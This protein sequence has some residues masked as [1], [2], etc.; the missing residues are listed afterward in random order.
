[1]YIINDSKTR[2]SPTPTTP[3]QAN[4]RVIF[5]VTST[6]NICAKNNLEEKFQG[7]NYVGTLH[8]FQ[9]KSFKVNKLI[10]ILKELYKKSGL[11]NR[12]NWFKVRKI[13]VSK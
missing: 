4:T 12:N 6:D 3:K 7:V 5:T 11:E 13:R 9:K 2:T 8:T 1:M 10:G